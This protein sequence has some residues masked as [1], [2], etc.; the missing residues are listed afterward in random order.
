MSD[1]TK[2]VAFDR[3]KLARLKRAYE[4]RL[5]E[6]SDATETFRFEGNEYVIGYAKYLIEYLD[7]EL[8]R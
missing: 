5:K 6:T 7:K 1:D 8:P 3:P 4:A 2:T